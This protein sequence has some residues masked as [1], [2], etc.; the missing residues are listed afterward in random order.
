MPD[1]LFRL[2]EEE[3]IQIEWWPLE[4]PL[5]GLYYRSRR[6]SHSIICISVH[7]TYRIHILRSVLA[8]ELGHHFTA[9]GGICLAPCRMGYMDR[10]RVTRAEERAL[11]W[12]VLHLIP[13]DDLVRAIRNGIT[14]Y[15][16]L[17]EHFRVTE[18]F[19]RYRLELSSRMGE[20]LE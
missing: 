9:S 17:T 8:E 2:A 6:I 14:S 10:L 19:M 3:G 5:L 15:H 1:S 12:A 11:R 16:E 4:A 13:R 7:I 18:G 20:R